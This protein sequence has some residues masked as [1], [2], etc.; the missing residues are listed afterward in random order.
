MSRHRFLWLAC[1][2]LLASPLSLSAQTTTGTVQGY[3]K[4]QQGAPIADAQVIARNTRNGQQTSVNSQPNGFY[5]LAGLTPSTYDVTVRRIGSAP[6]ARR[7]DVGVGQSLSLDFNLAASAVELTSVQVVATAAVELRTWEV[8]T[9]VTQQQVNNLP[10]WSRNFLDLASLAPGTSIQNDRLNGVA[11]SLSSGAQSADQINVFVDGASYKNDLIHGGVVGQDRSRGNPFPRNAIQEFR[12]LTQNYKAEYQKSSSAVLTAT[13][14]S[15]G[16]EW[17]ETAFFTYQNKS[18]VALDS[19]QTFDKHVADSIAVANG[20]PTTFRVPD[21]NRQLV[22][23]SAGGPIARDRLFFF[24][25][26]EGNYQNRS[27]RVNIVSPT[28]IPASAR[29][30]SATRTASTA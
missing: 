29:L 27:N 21:Y 7:L 24:G 30:I 25:S 1:I 23:L 13:T 20:T 8:A 15:G 4:D 10:S 26:Y 16:N 12:I 2:A 22:G 17:T 28:G 6:Q 18:L 9:N 19:V 3:I 11:R 14:R 5:I